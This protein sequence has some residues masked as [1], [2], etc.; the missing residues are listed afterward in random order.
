[1]NFGLFSSAS[2]SKAPVSDHALWTALSI[3]NKESLRFVPTSSLGFAKDS[4]FCAE[5]DDTTAN[6]AV[7]STA[8][9]PFMSEG[10]AQL[11]IV[12]S[13]KN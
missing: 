3:L 6:F 10:A 5:E 9:R 7:F 13:K 11:A 12:V 1:M 8:K 4:A 2:A